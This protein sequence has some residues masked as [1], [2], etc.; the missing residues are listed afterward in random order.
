M[1]KLIVKKDKKKSLMLNIHRCQGCELCIVAC[2]TGILEMSDRLNVRFANPPRVRAGKE[3][4]CQFCR[5]CELACPVWAIY[6]VEEKEDEGIS[7]EEEGNV[8]T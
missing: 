2:P 1:P 6:V 8:S 7:K 5:R 3:N 4:S